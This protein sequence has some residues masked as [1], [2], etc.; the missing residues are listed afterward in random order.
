LK[1]YINETVNS[2]IKFALASTSISHDDG[3]INTDN[4]W[5]SLTLIKDILKDTLN[6]GD[7][8]H[9]QTGSYLAILYKNNTRKWICRVNLYSSQK[10]IILPDE[11]KKE[12]KYPINNISDIRH[13]SNDIIAVTKRYL[14]TA[15]SD[16][17]TECL[18]TKWGI[19]EMPNPYKINLHRGPRNDLRKL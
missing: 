6:A 4:E 14:E 13:Y 5:E 7:I 10:T 16:K 19:Y 2:K 15:Q 3:R 8:Y 12:Q 17:S 18:H 11:N 9:K 1:G